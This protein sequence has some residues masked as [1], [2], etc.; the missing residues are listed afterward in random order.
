MSSSLGFFASQ[1][2]GHLYTL[3][4]SYDALATVTVPSGGASSITFSAI[5]QTGYKHLQLRIFGNTNGPYN[6][7]YMKFQFNGDTGSNYYLGHKLQA[8]GSSVAAYADGSGTSANIFANA[9]QNGSSIFAATI[10]D[11][12]DFT[13]VNKNKT[14]RSLSGADYNGSG[15]IYYESAM[16]FPSTPAGINSIYITSGTGSTFL[17][18]SQFALYG[19][20]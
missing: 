13:S 18:Y 1:I 12:L 19:V 4:G 9:G 11:I 7:D 14:I 3:T 17:Q 8:N 10:V 5:P 15:N 16:W 6:N 20:K 2:S